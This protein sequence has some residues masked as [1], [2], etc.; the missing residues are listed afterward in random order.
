MTQLRRFFRAVRWSARTMYL[1]GSYVRWRDAQLFQACEPYELRYGDGRTLVL[2]GGTG[3]DWPKLSPF[4]RSLRRFSNCR[5]LLIVSDP[6]VARTLNA[7]GVDTLT[8]VREP[9]YA[10]HPNFGRMGRYL[11]ALRA[12]EGQID[13][14]FLSD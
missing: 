3:Y 11:Q 10:P 6:Q 8:V 9:G 5:I 1:R 13:R 2:G 7:Q 12:L 4:V 14:V